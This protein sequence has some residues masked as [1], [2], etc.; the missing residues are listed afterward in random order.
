M[1]KALRDVAKY[2]RAKHGDIEQIAIDDRIADQEQDDLYGTH[3]ACMDALREALIGIDP[4]EYENYDVPNAPL[5]TLDEFL[6]FK[7]RWPDEASA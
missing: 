7:H 6:G 3:F 5:K 2:F 4:E 1:L